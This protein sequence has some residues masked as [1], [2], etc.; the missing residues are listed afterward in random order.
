MDYARLD[1]KPKYDEL[2]NNGNQL[3]LRHFSQ[4]ITEP[5]SPVR[6]YTSTGEF[7]ALYEFVPERNRYTP[8]KVFKDE[9]V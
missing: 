7:L 1:M 5:P 9:R 2:L 3:W 4:Y 8:L 6:V